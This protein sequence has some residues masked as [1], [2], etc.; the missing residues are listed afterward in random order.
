VRCPGYFRVPNTRDLALAIL[1]EAVPMFLARAV[2]IGR[3]L[4]WSSRSSA[5]NPAPRKRV[6]GNSSRE[7]EDQENP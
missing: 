3:I 7:G 4:I 1:A 2:P 6:C 5:E